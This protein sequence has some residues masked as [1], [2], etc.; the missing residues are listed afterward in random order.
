MIQLD[1][2]SRAFGQ[3]VLFDELSWRLDRGARIGLIGAN[4]SG[5]STLFRIITG[6][7]APDSG[8]V[9]VP[10]GVRVGMLPQEVGDIPDLPC[11]E[12]VLEGRADVLALEQDIHTLT[13]RIARHDGTDEE[14]V[15]LS[16]QLGQL[17]HD[18]ETGDGY[19]LRA[20][21]V[22]ILRGMGFDDDRIVMKASELSGGW[23]VRL[24]LSRLLLERPDV[25]LMDEPTNHLDLPSVEWLEGFLSTYDGTVVVIS[26]DRYFLNRLV[27]QTA[28]LEPDGLYI[29]PGGYDAWQ[30]A[31][32]ERLELLEKQREQQDRKIRETKKFI[33]RFRAKAT[34][35]KQVQSRVKQLEK[36]DR[37][38]LPGERRKNRGFHF[39]E[40]QRPGRDVVT[41]ESVGKHYG[42]HVVYDAVDL[43]IE[44]GEKLV[45]VG[46]NGAGK[47]T[48]LKLVAE[49]IQPDAGEVRLGHNVQVGYFG[50]HQVDELDPSRTILEEMEAFATVDTAPRCRSVLGA[51]L[52][53]GDEVGKKIS[54]LSGGER[55]RVALAKMLLRPAN[56]LL[57]DEP[58]NHLDI[59]SRDVLETAMREF[60]GTI[61]FVSHDRHFINAVA[62][63]VVHVEARALTDYPGDYEYY[64]YKRGLE[65]AER[66]EAEAAAAEPAPGAS[67]TDASADDGP[68]L[69]R[70]EQRRLD[71]E[72]RK[73]MRAAS[74]RLRDRLAE[75]EADV[76]KR[77]ARIEAIET[78]LANPALY[79]GDRGDE[80]QTL[81][82]EL[83]EAKDALDALYFEWADL[84][85]R[86]E[87]AEVAVREKF[88]RMDDE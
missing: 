8:R 38:E 75:V 12:F 9:I 48:L 60:D 67:A 50:Q 37:I 73:A 15:A 81:Q 58:T 68:K 35:A 56:L 14:L 57:L 86:A 87:A 29:T 31:R 84:S 2:I 5:K 23:K 27:T 11:V 43:R 21:A 47:S 65:A 66:E 70:K 54:V 49:R 39:A 61:V 62:T 1:R 32:D 59:E 88:G 63:R 22:T 13:D 28:A 4:G 30:K 77:E 82:T 16:E 53:T 18:F 26:H 36:I 71:A 45:L 40:A 55:N 51:F 69:S 25:L 42:D 19:R 7:L 6:E 64:H 52:F 20:R 10:S 34:K 80:V 79:E 33:D 3:R 85:E 17:Q 78:E 72:F 76:A 83:A 24:V 46:P 74:G 44:R 41:V